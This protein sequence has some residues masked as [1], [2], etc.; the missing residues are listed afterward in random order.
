MDDMT[1]LVRAGMV[2]AA[3]GLFVASYFRFSNPVRLNL[4]KD[5]R[6]PHLAVDATSAA[7]ESSDSRRAPSL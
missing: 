5:R 3:T 2:F 6:A 7:A 4:S 1:I